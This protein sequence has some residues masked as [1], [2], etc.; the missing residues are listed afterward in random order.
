MKILLLTSG[1]PK[2]ER[3]GGIW[4]PELIRSLNHLGCDVHIL[5]QNCDH[6]KTISE[7]LWPGCRVTYFN[8]RGGDLPLISVLGLGISGIPLA[9]QF[10]INGVL[11][12]RKI[13]RQWKP[14]VIF[15]EWLVPS[16]IIAYLIAKLTKIPYA[17]RTLGS[18][19][20]KAEQNGLIRIV[21]RLIAENSAML[22]ADGFDL[23]SKT[24]NLAGGKPC[25]FA[26]TSRQLAMLRSDFKQPMDDGIFTTCT[27]GRLHPVKGQDI[28]VDAAKILAQRNIPF[29]SYIVGDGP[30]RNRLQETITRM[31][32]GSKVILTGRLEDGDIAELL[33]HVDCVI[34]PSRSESIPLS[35]GEAISAKKPLIVSSVGDLP[36]LVDKYGLGY[37]VPVD[38]TVSL[39]N[40]IEQMHLHPRNHLFAEAKIYDEL[41]TMLSSKG[42]AQTIYETIQ[43]YQGKNC[44]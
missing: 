31:G 3:I 39:A 5:T 27:V 44:A 1:F 43:A 28:L 32:L 33:R 21:A 13:C 42:A 35:F 29:R 34:I 4:I 16:G 12:G 15:A 10:V 18:D 11:E 26:A 24:S 6:S 9:S 8:W 40:A 25:V 17:V 23:C 2:G 19:V 14:D 41:M 38:D 36:Y 22:F 20:L 37:V 30:E 7:T